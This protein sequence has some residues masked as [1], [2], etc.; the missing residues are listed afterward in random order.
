MYRS[1]NPS[2]I[3]IYGR[4][5]GKHFHL[6]FIEDFIN[7]YVNP[8]K[9]KL[10][11]NLCIKYDTN[12]RQPTVDC[13]MGR[14]LLLYL[15]KVYNTQIHRKANGRESMGK[16]VLKV[17][18]ILESNVVDS[19]FKYEFYWKYDVPIIEPQETQCCKMKGMTPSVQYANRMDA[20][21]LFCFWNI[22]LIYNATNYKN[23]K[24]CQSMLHEMDFRLFS[25]NAN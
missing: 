18:G 20:L 24:L 7:K 11:K 3:S 19:D 21:S 13:I 25:C 15:Q 1:K 22:H 6:Y 10:S 4:I 9:N 2:Y 16:S 8:Y 5:Q 23:V 14:L 12:C 17:Q